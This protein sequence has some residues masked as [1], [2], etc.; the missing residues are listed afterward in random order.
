[1]LLFAHHSVNKHH[2][3]PGTLKGAGGRVMKKARSPPLLEFLISLG[4]QTSGQWQCRV[5]GITKEGSAG[6]LP[7]EHTGRASNLVLEFGEGLPV[8][9]DIGLRDA[10]CK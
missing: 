6:C 2:R 4:R 10:A 9:G 1:M 5:A 7:L 3:E 8:Q